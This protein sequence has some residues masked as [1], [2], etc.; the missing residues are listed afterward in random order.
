MVRRCQLERQNVTLSLSRDLLKQ[1][2]HL[3]IE[4]GT[5]LSGLLSHCL[6]DLVKK[7]AGYDEAASRIAARLGKGLDLGTGGTCTWTRDSLHER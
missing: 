3:A 6:E 2:K 1:A 4:K 7:E 5:S